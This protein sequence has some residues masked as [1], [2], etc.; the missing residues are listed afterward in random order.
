MKHIHILCCALTILLCFS[1]TADKEEQADFRAKFVGTY[2]GYR[3]CQPLNTV[4]THPDQELTI[5]VDYGDKS[6]YL[7][8]DTDQVEVDSNGNFPYPYFNGYRQYGLSFKNDSIF[9]HQQW[10]ALNTNET[11]KFRGKKE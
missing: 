10:G 8:V 5:T 9:I 1:C 2:K 4:Q 11:C 7:L 6:N 3:D